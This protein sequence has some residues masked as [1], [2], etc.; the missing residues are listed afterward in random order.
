MPE[1]L[2]EVY[3]TPIPKSPDQGI[4]HPDKTRLIALT[5]MVFRTWSATRASHLSKMWL[6]LV[7]GTSVIGGIKG[8]GTSLASAW[9]DI[10]WDLASIEKN[11]HMSVFLDASKCFDNLPLEDIWHLASE[12]GMPKEVLVPAKGLAKLPEKGASPT[13]D[14]CLT[15]APTAEG[16]LQGDPPVS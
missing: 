4:S 8:R 5:S 1:S 11:P 3:L 13:W 9:M 7:A 6:P 15:N 16:V 12:L 14:G 2:C 10:G